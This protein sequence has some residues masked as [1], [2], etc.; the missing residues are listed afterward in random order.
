[1]R[2]LIILGQLIFVQYSAFSYSSSYDHN[3]FV[4]LLCSVFSTV[5]FSINLRHCLALL[6]ESF[7][8][9][10]H[11]ENGIRAEWEYPFAV[12]GINIS[13]MLTQMLDLQAG[14]V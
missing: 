12:A 5:C 1:M 6:Q 7:Q 13:F 3:N 8:R 14:T 2:K 11:K 10:L 4:S 9:L